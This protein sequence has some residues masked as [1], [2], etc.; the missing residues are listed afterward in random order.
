MLNCN[1]RINDELR[2]I[3]YWMKVN[4]LSLNVKKSKFMVFHNIGKKVDLPDVFMDD[5]RIEAVNSFNFLGLTLDH[6]INWTDHLT[7]ISNKIS[8]AVGIL[9]KLKYFLPT[10]IK[11]M[12]Y[13]S[14]ILPHINFGILNWGFKLNRIEKLQK[15][16]L[17]WITCSNYNAHTDPLFKELKVLKVKDIFTQMKLKCYHKFTNKNLPNK[18]LSLPFKS[19]QEIHSY[20]TRGSGELFV[21][22]VNT[23]RAKQSLKYDIPV[24]VNNTPKNITDK[25]HTHSLQGFGNYI[26]NEFLK[27]YQSVCSILNCY[28]C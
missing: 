28:V 23:T 21:N 15:K 7:K 9:N 3:N 16:A 18:L 1:N 5:T 11:L 24:V 2:N 17:R 6:H 26:K 25:F 13:N 14:L 20:S 8:Q 19:R 12:I 4:E 10:H 27:S 22:R